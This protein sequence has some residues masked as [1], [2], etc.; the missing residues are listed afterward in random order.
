MQRH[1]RRRWRQRPQHSHAHSPLLAKV[2]AIDVAAD[3]A[4]AVNH[5]GLVWVGVLCPQEAQ[6]SARARRRCRG[7]VHTWHACA[8][9]K[10]VSSQCGR[11]SW[12]VGIGLL[13][14]G[15]HPLTHCDTRV[16]GS[17]A[18]GVRAG[19]CVAACIQVPA[20][21]TASLQAGIRKSM[22]PSLPQNLSALTCT[23]VT[24]ARTAWC[25]PLPTWSNLQIPP[26]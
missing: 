19:Q 2:R 4:G 26:R 23:R 18:E 8:A 25:T 16:C 3:A 17:R 24:Q 12:L 15:T 1:W 5:D 6:G 14:M 10:K 9:F 13:E 21:T 20:C 11:L 22:H 7:H